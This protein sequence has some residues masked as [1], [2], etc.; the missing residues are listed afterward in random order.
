MPQATVTLTFEVS[1]DR[2]QD[3]VTE[4]QGKAEELA[5]LWRC[6]EVLAGDDLRCQFGR[7]HDGNRHVHDRFSWYVGPA[8]Q[9]MRRRSGVQ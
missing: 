8:V 1:T 2:L 4:M 3:F 9:E 7:G 6:P 5:D